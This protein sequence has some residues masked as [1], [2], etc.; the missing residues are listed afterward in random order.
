MEILVKRE[1]YAAVLLLWARPTLRITMIV[2][3][4]V[5]AHISLSLSPSMLFS[6]EW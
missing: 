4:P 2:H 3:A 5:H 1:M 6:R